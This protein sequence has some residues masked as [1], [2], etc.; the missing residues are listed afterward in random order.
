[1]QPTSERSLRALSVIFFVA[2]VAVGSGPASQAQ[3]PAQSDLERPLVDPADPLLQ[4]VDEAI[5]VTSRRY[6]QA[7]RHSPWQIMHGLLALRRDYQIKR[8]DEKTNAL[9]WV[10]SG[11]MYNGEPWF[12]KTRYG[13]RPHPY[14]KAYAFEGHPN[15]FLAILTMCELPLDYEFKTPGGA[16][17]MQEM[18]YTAQ[19]EVTS[20]EEITWTLWALS[21]YLEPDAT[22]ENKWGEAWSME[23]LVRMQTRASVYNAACG[24]THA[25]FAITYARNAYRKTG[26]ALRGAWLEADQKI[27]RYIEE[28]RS[29]QNSDG[30]FSSQYFRG[31]GQARDFATRVSTSGHML[32]FLMLALP[33]EWLNQDWVRRAV[34]AVAKELIDHSR[35]PLEPGAMYHA[36]DGLVIYRDRV[37]PQTEGASQLAEAP[38]GEKAEAD[39]PLPGAQ[40]P[41]TDE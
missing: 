17:S 2:I 5:D 36:L 7:E 1:M 21:H 6:L 39:P 24:G 26:D 30:T 28:A 25:M 35:D 29:N 12:E 10:S 14:T 40:R 3:Q 18:V 37:L 38:Q 4:R 27:R 9:E 34:A 11:P 13:G 16:V 33:D 41:G 31:R 22:W 20:R 15:Q 8:G 23:R 19:K 32:E